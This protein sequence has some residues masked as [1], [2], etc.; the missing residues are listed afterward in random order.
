MSEAT[1]NIVNE[2]VPYTWGGQWTDRKLLAFEKYVKAYLK[3]MNKNRKQYKWK[4]IYFDGFAGS[5]ERDQQENNTTER[6]TL[7]PEYYTEDVS[8]YAYKGAAERVVSL[9][10]DGFDYY[11]FIDNDEASNNKLKSKLKPYQQKHKMPFEYR[12]S[13]ANTQLDKFTAKCNRK[14]DVKYKTLM[15]LDPFGMQIKWD[16]LEKL[17]NCDVDLWI[18]VPTGVIINRLLDRQGKLTHIDIL[19]SYFGLS[20]EEISNY[21]YRI[22]KEPTLF[23]EE[24]TI[25]K[26]SKP[27]EEISKLYIKRLKTIFPYVLENPLVLRNS[28][29][30]P[31]FHFVFASHNQTALK[32]AKSII[33]P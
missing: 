30:C 1:Q 8:T 21:F 4:L 27:I 18:L 22:K 12:T 2:P 31:I 10:C 13:D 25:N 15:L 28:T 29:N 6:P 32:I 5:G 23:G 16:S 33:Q 26:I 17:R 3:I 7:F 14:S 9:D 11:Y 20:K 24:T 19:T